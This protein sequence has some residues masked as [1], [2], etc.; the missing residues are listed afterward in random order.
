M[1]LKVQKRDAFGGSQSAT[2]RASGLVPAE[3][4]GHGV[5]NV[6]LAVPVKDMMS[7]YKQAGESEIIN[8]VVDGKTTPVLIHDVQFHPISQDFQS[9]DFYEVDMNAELELAV[10]FEFV[11][12]APAIKNFGGILT[13]AMDEVEVRCL[14]ANIP[15]DIK[16]DLSVLVNLNQSIYV[17]DLPNSDKYKIVSDPNN[18]IVSISEPMKEEEL[19]PKPEAK[20]EDVKVETELKKDARDAAKTSAAPEAGAKKEVKK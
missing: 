8:L 6:H 19:A 4:Y 16:I 7:A 11:G 13:K 3:L 1:E 5:K 2:L 9:V 14:P 20:V 17:R 18:A 12:E 10:P 15:Q